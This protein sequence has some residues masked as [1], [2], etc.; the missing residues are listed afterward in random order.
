MSTPAAATPVLAGAGIRVGAFA[1]DIAAIALCTVVIAVGLIFSGLAT[2][3]TLE[4]PGLGRALIHAGALSSGIVPLVALVLYGVLAGRR[5]A[6][7][8][9]RILNLQ[10]V[11]L[12]SHRPVGVGGGMLRTA[13]LFAPALLVLALRL[14]AVLLAP[15]TGG[16]LGPNAWGG[17]VI[18][19]LTWVI[20]LWWI[21]LAAQLA[22]GR[23]A[24]HDRAAGTMVLALRV[25]R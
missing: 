8:G 20:P 13:V 25:R 2:P 1:I 11:S 19:A 9:Q 18:A 12:D 15:L 5:G 7:A 6:S 21:L 23:R 14:A 10:V 17:G 22:T 4:G 24:L 3:G 16:I